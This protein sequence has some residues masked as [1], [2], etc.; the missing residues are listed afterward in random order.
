MKRILVTCAHPDDETLGMGGTLSVNIKNGAKIFV[1][2]CADGETSR[3]KNQTWVKKRQKQAENALSIL[4]VKEYEF[5]YYPDQLLEQI[6]LLELSG[7][8]E[9]IIKKWK[10][11]TVY[12]HFNG[13]LNQDHRRVFEATMIAV[14][15]VP[16]SPIQN[17]ICFETPS[18]TEWGTVGFHPNYF[19][20][21]K[22]GIKQK[23]KAM[24]KYSEE[25]K[26]APHPRSVKSLI[27]RAE[28]WGSIIGRE[29]AEAFIQIR[30]ID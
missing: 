15:P 23:I 4:G 1:L 28:Y 20:D 11:D 16:K 3:M 22:S 13:D 18:S 25:V 26:A 5:L 2:I 10:P 19:V 12:T 8:I 30:K 9:K 29:S 7:K 6:S 21:I 14:R 27:N 17:V 24:K